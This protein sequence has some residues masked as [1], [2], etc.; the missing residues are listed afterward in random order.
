MKRERKRRD[1]EGWKHTESEPSIAKTRVEKAR[2]IVM[3]EG[4]RY[5][6]AK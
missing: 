3:V 1:I 6:I 2:R 4:K 5:M